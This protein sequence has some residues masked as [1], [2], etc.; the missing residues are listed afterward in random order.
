MKQK[1]SDRKESR[2]SKSL[3]FRVKH[4]PVGSP[5][6]LQNELLLT[7]LGDWNVLNK[8]KVFLGLSNDFMTKPVETL[9]ES[10]YVHYRT[11]PGSHSFTCSWE[12]G[13]LQTYKLLQGLCNFRSLNFSLR[14]FC[15]HVDY[16]YKNEIYADKYWLL[17]NKHKMYK[18][19]YCF[20]IKACRKKNI[21]KLFCVS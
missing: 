18:H 19:C 4:G 21:L 14:A 17:Q 11:L 10:H 3:L 9:I 13:P 16:T 20:Q 7:F 5:G 12:T 8:L 15:S 2:A 6:S 1:K